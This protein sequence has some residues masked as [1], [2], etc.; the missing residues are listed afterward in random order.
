MENIIL[1]GR[2]GK[3]LFADS[4]W[5]KGMLSSKAI[6]EARPE[7]QNWSGLRAVACG[8]GQ[9][10]GLHKDGTV[11]ACG[12]NGKGQCEVGDFRGVGM[13]AASGQCTALVFRDGTVKTLG[14]YSAAGLSFPQIV[15]AACFGLGKIITL[16]AQGALHGEMLSADVD[17]FQKDFA[18]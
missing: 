17:G 5:K 6:R 16:D 18:W 13:I 7:I 14:K 8:S 4:I 9:F 2:D 10:V 15:A 11:L 3:I 12:E 1:L